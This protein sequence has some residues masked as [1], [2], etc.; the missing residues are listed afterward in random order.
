MAIERYLDFGAL[1]HFNPDLEANRLP[2]RLRSPEVPG[3]SCRALPGSFSDG[4]GMNELGWGDSSPKLL[5]LGCDE[6]LQIEGQSSGQ[7][8]AQ[9]AKRRHSGRN[10][11]VTAFP[12]NLDRATLVPIGTEIID[13]TAEFR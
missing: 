2:S 3:Q 4:F 12:C 9:G 10:R 8:A 6:L 1:R 11:L 5:A 13:G 7:S